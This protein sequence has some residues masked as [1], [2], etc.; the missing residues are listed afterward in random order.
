MKKDM[1][2][3]KKSKKKKLKNNGQK[4]LK[5]YNSVKESLT[6]VSYS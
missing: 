5:I 3:H 1:K 4:Y 2:N 6:A